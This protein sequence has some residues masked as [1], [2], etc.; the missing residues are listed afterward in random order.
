M[1]SDP[2][3]AI[4]I[5]KIAGDVIR[6]RA[7]EWGI[8]IWERGLPI[9]RKDLTARDAEVLA[10]ERKGGC[11]SANSAISSAVSVV[12]YYR[13]RHSSGKQAGANRIE[14]ERV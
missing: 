14:R 2:S 10:E 13:A 6:V 9:A 1:A 3:A 7:S 12:N 11:F 5:S 4:W 8:E